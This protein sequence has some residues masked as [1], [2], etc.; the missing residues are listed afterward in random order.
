MAISYDDWKKQYEGLTTDQQKKYADMV[1]NDATATEYANRY[2]QEKQNAGKAL[3]EDSHPDGLHPAFE[4]RMPEGQ[5]QPVYQFMEVKPDTRVATPNRA[6]YDYVPS[7]TTVEAP[8]L[9]PVEFENVPTKL[10]Q[11]VK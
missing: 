2:I 5:S 11:G 10:N 7:R 4:A 1:K 9:S 6:A 8:V 3:L